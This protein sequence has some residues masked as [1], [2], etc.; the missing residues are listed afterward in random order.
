M[1]AGRTIA[2]IAAAILIFFGIAFVYGAF[3]PSGSI[4]W[5]PVG[6]VS[7]TAGLGLIWFAR[8]REKMEFTTEIVQKIELSGDVN[9]EKIKCEFCGG[10]LGSDNIAMVAGAPVVTCPFCGSSYQIT[11]APKW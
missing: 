7:I 3:S 2:N 4:G 5:I 9:L 11:E 8:R 10:P 6:V 1:K